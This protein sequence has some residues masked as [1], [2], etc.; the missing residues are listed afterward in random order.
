MTR[1]QARSDY[2]SCKDLHPVID[3]ARAQGWRVEL[4]N[5]NHLRFLSRDRKVPPVYGPYTPS[6]H[7]SVKNLITKLRHAGLANV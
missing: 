7:R 5:S 2:P 4:T 6:D 3:A 1:I